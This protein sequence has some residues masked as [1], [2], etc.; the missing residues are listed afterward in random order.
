MRDHVSAIKPI[1]DGSLVAQLNAI[2]H[3]DAELKQVRARAE[4][5]RVAAAQARLGRRKSI[6]GLG[7]LRMEIDPVVF[8]YWGQRLGYE[9][10]D[11]PQFLREFERDN[12]EVRVNCGGTRTQV[13]A[14]GM[15][16]AST[17]RSG[18]VRWR[19]SYSEMKAA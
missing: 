3:R 19:K 8:H 9:C 17:T 14:R 10:W 12:A 6:E 13:G 1:T 7:R 18:G 4:Q 15:G 16:L 5:V 11:D 2:F